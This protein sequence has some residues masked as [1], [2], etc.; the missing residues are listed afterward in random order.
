VST[1]ST[2]TG[3]N[4]GSTSGSFNLQLNGGQS[5]SLDQVSKISY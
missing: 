3:V 4:A 5:I 1:Y 2:V